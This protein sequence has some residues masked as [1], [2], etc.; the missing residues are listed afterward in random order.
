MTEPMLKLLGDVIAPYP[1]GLDLRA[2]V[3]VAV[4]MA[5]EGMD[6][7]AEIEAAL[8]GFLGEAH[9]DKLRKVQQAVARAGLWKVGADRFVTLVAHLATQG[10]LEVPDAA[11]ALAGLPHVERRRLLPAARHLVSVADAVA[12]DARE[13]V[14]GIEDDDFFRDAL[15]ALVPPA[16]A[17][18]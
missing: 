7:P 2:R 17:S 14:M 18:E 3:D 4:A 8:N 9:E 13:G 12:E 1:G 5:V 15:R 11:R 16:S 6:L 10:M